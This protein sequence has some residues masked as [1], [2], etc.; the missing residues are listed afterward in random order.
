MSGLLRCMPPLMLHE[1]EVLISFYRF[2]LDGSFDL[3]TGGPES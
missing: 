3:K 2:Y 1:V